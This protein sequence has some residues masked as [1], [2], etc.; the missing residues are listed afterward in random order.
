MHASLRQIVTPAGMTLLRAPTESLARV[1]HELNHRAD[2]SRRLDSQLVQD[3][4][5]LY[6]DGAELRRDGRPRQDL[7][8][9]DVYAASLFASG[10]HYMIFDHVEPKGR[11]L[12]GT[13]GSV[14]S[15]FMADAREKYNMSSV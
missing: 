13:L 5:E 14:G 10:T 7:I 2:E 11:S 6:G 1:K 8:W 4:Y 9:K 3:I 12:L 15:L